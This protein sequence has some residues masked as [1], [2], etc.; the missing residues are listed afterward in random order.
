MTSGMCVGFVS[1][2]AAI[3]VLVR[4]YEKSEIIQLVDG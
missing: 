3:K 2:S 1:L 4:N